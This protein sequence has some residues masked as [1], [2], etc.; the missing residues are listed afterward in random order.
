MCQGC[1][2]QAQDER[3]ENN[4]SYPGSVN[5]PVAAF[6]GLVMTDAYTIIRQL[7]C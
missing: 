7:L 1:L 5:L 4:A 2:P 6:V 3:P